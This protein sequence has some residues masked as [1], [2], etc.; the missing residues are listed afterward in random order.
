MKFLL[1]LLIILL[2]QARIIRRL[3]KITGF[4]MGVILVMTGVL[5]LGIYVVFAAI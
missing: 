1:I 5:L 2:V 4:L 3:F